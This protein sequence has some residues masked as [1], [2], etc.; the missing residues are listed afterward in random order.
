MNHSTQQP[1]FFKTYYFLFSFTLGS[2]ESLVYWS[3][4]RDVYGS[5]IRIYYVFVNTI[6]SNT[7]INNSFIRLPFLADTY[8]YCN[9]NYLLNYYA[10]ER[11]TLLKLYIM[12][13]AFVRSVLFATRKP[14]AYWFS[15][16][17]WC[18]ALI[19]YIVPGLVTS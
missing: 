6:L 13:R 4:L 9:P 18:Q 17:I 10:Y 8:S 16:N 14:G 19:L 5:Y 1:F 15:T 11:F 7:L 3:L 2:L 12:Y